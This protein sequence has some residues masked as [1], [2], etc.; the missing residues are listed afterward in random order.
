MGVKYV[1][2]GM[3]RNIVKGAS[4][5]LL[6]GDACGFS[7]RKNAE[8]R[9]NTVVFRGF[10]AFFR[11]ERRLAGSDS[12]VFRSALKI[13][14]SLLFLFFV[15]VLL[16]S[17]SP[18]SSY[19]DMEELEQMRERCLQV[20]PSSYSFE[21][22]HTDYVLLRKEIKVN[23]DGSVEI[24]YGMPQG[25]EVENEVAEGYLKDEFGIRFKE[26]SSIDDAFDYIRFF[27]Q[28]KLDDKAERGRWWYLETSVK[29]DEAHF[30]PYEFRC[31][32]HDGS[33]VIDSWGYSPASAVEVSNF[34][35][36]E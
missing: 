24:K 31:G 23:V 13:Y 12:E 32:I 4:K 6:F 16:F 33:P 35:V 1:T 25:G 28:K 30:Y 34:K 14:P 18:S 8:K 22:E 2:F 26:I 9:R 20:L 29:Y 5:N 21:V 19:L 11:P 10:P 36:L 15:S 27:Y 3:I 17:C 7:R